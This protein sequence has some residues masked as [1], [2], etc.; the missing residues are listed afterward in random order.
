MSIYHVFISHAWHY[1]DQ[2]NRVVDWL[3]ESTLLFI[4]YSVPKHDPVDANNIAKL[5]AALTEQISHA[6][7]VIII[8]GMYTVHS[9]WIDYEINEAIRMRKVIIALKPWGNKVM[10][11]KLQNVANEIVNWNS[12]SLISAILKY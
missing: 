2:Y 10:P 4:N 7:I 5:K 8:A 11:T 1:G 9:D 3:E 12:Q 6:N